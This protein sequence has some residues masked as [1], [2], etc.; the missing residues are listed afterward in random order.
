MKTTH[1]RLGVLAISGLVLSVLALADTHTQDQQYREREQLDPETGTWV[2][3]PP[4]TSA[5]PTDPLGRARALLASGQPKE[6]REILE[7]WIEQNPD[8][9]RYWEGVLLLG[10]AWFERGDYWKAV[11]RFQTVGENAAGALFHRANWRCVDVARA[12]LSGEKRI[13]WKIFRLP[14]YDDGV[15]I[16]DRVWEREP[17]SHIGEVALKTK[18]D[19]YFRRGDMDLAQDEYANL[20]RQFPYGRYAQLAMLRTAV[21]AEASFP[22]VRFDDQPLI[23][24]TEHYRQL[25]EAYPA[26]AEREGVAQRLEGIRQERA[27]KDLTIAKWYERTRQPDAA[28]F[29]YR[30]ILADWP[31][32]LAAADARNRLR[33][34]GA[35]VAPPAAPAREDDTP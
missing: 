26:Y 12:F 7:P 5:D 23:E 10:E 9:E 31:D 4:E 18:A 3:A 6:A 33:A 15:D 35:E 11:E 17:G 19:Y 32:T 34:L 30:Q 8:S 2:E 1:H 16:L 22:G 28:V 14:A 29:Y 24:A 25:Q 27:E 20:V 21:A 13:L